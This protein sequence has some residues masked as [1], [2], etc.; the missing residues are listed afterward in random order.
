MN[1]DTLKLAE[2]RFMQHYPGGFHH[3]E[4]QAI[5]KKHKMDR[6]VALAQDEF[7]RSRFRKTDSIAES[8]VKIVSRSSLISLFE[9]P[10]FRDGVRTMAH[11][12]K[13]I[14]A[15]GLE[16]FLHGRQQTGF[17]AMTL[18]LAQWKLAKWPLLTLIP[19]YYRPHDEVLVK[20]TTAKGIIEYF[21]LKD[22][23]YSAKPNWD[24]YQR[25]RATILDMKHCVDASLAPSNAAFLGFLLLSFKTCDGRGGPFAPPHDSGPQQSRRF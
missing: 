2:A 14:L 15:A 8:M 25:F 24:F 12:E 21:E 23:A 5:G 19:N 1:L 20:P 18:V 6:M 10:R 9:K 7:A 4:L 16:D 3:P 17:E 11:A 22:L 13:D